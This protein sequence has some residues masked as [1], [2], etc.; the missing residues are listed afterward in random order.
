MGT[1]AR[2]AGIMLAASAAVSGCT[3][4]AHHE[5]P[6]PASRG[7]QDQLIVQDPHPSAG[8]VASFVIKNI[9]AGPVVVR[10]STRRPVRLA[11]PGSTTVRVHVGD[12]SRELLVREASGQVLLRTRVEEGG[13]W[14]VLARSFGALISREQP[15]SVGPAS[16]GC[17]G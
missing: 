9:D 14:Y 4:P 16:L 13:R 8:G 2:L 1:G 5:A 3:S 7:E 17:V 12:G 15:V 10:P 11:C 6:T